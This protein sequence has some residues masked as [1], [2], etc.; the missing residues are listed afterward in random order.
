MNNVLNYTVL[1]CIHLL[2]TG[3]SGIIEHFWISYL[4]HIL[5]I[6]NSMCCNFDNW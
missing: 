5:L 4:I 2:E 3:D 1:L 6:I